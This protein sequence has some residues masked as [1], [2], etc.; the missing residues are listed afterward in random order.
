MITGAARRLV[1]VATALM[2]PAR[3]D[4]GRAIAA[5]LDSAS[6]RSDQVRLALGA[7]R[8]ALLPPPGLADYGRAAGRAARMAA[9]AFIPLGTGIYLV[10]VLSPGDDSTPGV[11]AM[12]AYLVTALMLAGALARRAAAKPGVAVIGGIVAGLVLGAL[13]LA[14]LEVSGGTVALGA[15]VELCAAG[16]VL[17]PVGASLARELAIA[18]SHVRRLGG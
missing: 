7:V 15:V 12:D 4:W 16:A 17:A 11:L 5:E 6:S 1:I 14:T 2:P 3:R 9:I 8:V 10:N 18:W 13:G